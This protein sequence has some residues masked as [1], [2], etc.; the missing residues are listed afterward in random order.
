MQH[1]HK[2]F[3]R[4]DDTNTPGSGGV[5]LVAKHLLSCVQFLGFH[6]SI[7]LAWVRVH[8]VAVGLVYAR[9]SLLKR[10]NGSDSMQKQAQFLAL[11][12]SSVAEQQATGRQVLLMGDFNAKLGAL[13]D[14]HDMPRLLEGRHDHFGSMLMDWAPTASL[15][16]LTGRLDMCEHSWQRGEQTSRIDHAFIQAGL[17]ESVT[18]WQVVND[19]YGSDHKP[20]C[21][22][23][24]VAGA[25]APAPAQPF[26]R[27]DFNRQA[28][29]S[30]FIAGQSGAFDNIHGALDSGDVQA[31]CGAVDE[32]VRGAASAVGLLHT[33]GQS[34]LHALP[35]GQAAIDVR[36]E[37]RALR[38]HGCPVPAGLRRLWR[39]HVRAGRHTHATQQHQRMRE[40]LKKHPRIFWSTLSNS[41][42]RSS[43]DGILHVTAWQTYFAEKFGDVL[44]SPPAAHPSVQ[45]IPTDPNCLLMRPVT[46]GDVACAFKQVGTAKATGADGIPAEFITKAYTESEGSLFMRVIARMCNIVLQ[47]GCIPECWKTKLITP[48]FKAGA[49]HDPANY[50]PIAVATTFYRLFTAVFAQRLTSYLHF[51]EK[52]ARLLDCQ[53]AF[54]KTLS[55]DHAHVV[56]TTC[57]NVAL[58]RNQPLALVKLDVSK[59]Y[60][61]VVRQKLWASL[62]DDGVPEAF[63]MLL[64]ELYRDTP[65]MVK[66]NGQVSS[67]FYTDTG[68]LQGCALSPSLY[69][70][71]L[72]SC[73]L[74][75]EER[76]KHM[77]IHLHG[78]GIQCVQ[79]DFADDIHGTVALDQVAAFLE[80]VQAV[81]AEKGQRLNVDKCKVLVISKQ[82]YHASHIAGLPVVTEHKILGLVYTHNGC[83]DASI[84][85]RSRKG[86]TKAVL[87]M[88]RLRRFGCH[89]DLAIASLMIKQDVRPTLLFGAG[90]WGFHHL[91]Y[92][93]PMQHPLQKPYSILQRMALAQPHC[94]AHWTVTVMTGLM[95]IQHWVIRDFCRLWN[96]V[97]V[98]CGED[99]ALVSQCV[100]TQI[101][102]FQHRKPCWLKRWHDAF[103][104]L[105]PEAEVHTCLANQ[106]PIDE[107]SVHAALHASYLQVMRTM[108]NPFA[109]AECNHRKIAFAWHMLCCQHSWQH[110][111][112]VV[113]ISLPPHV[114]STWLRMLAGNAHIPARHY[115]FVCMEP[116]Y[117]HRVCA[118]CLLAEV[119]DESHIL[120]RCTATAF[121]R[122][123][124]RSC[125]L[126][127]RSLPNFIYN[128][129]YAWDKLPYYVYNA[130]I[131]YHIAPQVGV[132]DMP[133][134]QRSLLLRQRRLVPCQ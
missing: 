115:S 73:L 89:E 102:L 98:V 126:W 12:H 8:D 36:D 88:S 59:A 45:P 127:P 21:L 87:H 35:L 80:V 132:D 62:R 72:R 1:S 84:C 74:Q 17:L 42:M 67:P 44:Q 117:R 116:E 15:L 114:R 109:L 63:I 107:Q 118:K 28:V 54:R 78:D 26:L 123:C 25:Q 128:N 125:M 19:F 105:I 32:L 91:A 18:S 13:S 20:L 38:K 55:T 47:T 30:A 90:I 49:R 4:T 60:D 75:I 6:E 48:V 81:L 61:T 66:V 77:G 122:D 14:G 106:Q 5:V 33:R 120:L 110:V 34:K 82:P 130:M 7:P 58:S 96:R 53:F 134:G 16:T 93:D 111:P 85:E 101:H 92:T 37:I 29:Y 3:A 94:T 103:L 27:W 46:V 69:N 97:L 22:T 43:A 64:Q 119:A 56:L 57:C 41:G 2:A 51:E 104:K 83:M 70:K 65:Y 131:A 24:N 129:R 121:E 23:L 76:C 113:S 124:F 133:L 95:P 9:Y 40:L 10:A 31:A 52:P 108:G 50:R 112:R 39:L 79:V 11:L 99:N 68:V 100:S 86:A 71:Y